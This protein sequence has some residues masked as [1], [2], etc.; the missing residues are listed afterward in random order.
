M[1]QLKFRSARQYAALYRTPLRSVAMQA[2]KRSTQAGRMHEE[3]REGRLLSYFVQDGPLNRH[4]VLRDK[5][6]LMKR[7]HGTI[8]RTGQSLLAR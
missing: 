7:R 2:R 1:R 5:D 3:R 8:L 6:R 4:A